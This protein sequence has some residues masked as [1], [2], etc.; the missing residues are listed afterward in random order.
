MEGTPYSPQTSL[1]DKYEAEIAR[2]ARVASLSIVAIIVVMTVV[3]IGFIMM[4][5]G[6]WLV[7]LAVI[8]LGYGVAFLV[9]RTYVRRIKRFDQFGIF[10]FRWSKSRFAVGLFLTS[11][12]MVLF[13]VLSG[14][15]GADYGELVIGVAYLLQ[16]IGFYFLA[17][18][19]SMTRS[20]IPNTS[21]DLEQWVCEHDRKNRE[22]I[23]SAFQ[24]GLRRASLYWRL[25][26]AIGV[27]SLTLG[28]VAM[29]GSY[30]VMVVVSS[31]L[32]LAMAGVNYL[33]AVGYRRR[34]PAME[35]ELSGP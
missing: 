21:G 19:L 16:I 17:A 2:R 10:A 23:L 34:I 22:R 24:K 11:L 1:T 8:T 15:Q 12:A 13:G 18:S 26:G 25:F 29:S 33:L 5:M 32:I 14:T 31:S 6:L 35:Q 28:I 30:Q 7:S 9:M 20:G 4:M 3:T 27:G